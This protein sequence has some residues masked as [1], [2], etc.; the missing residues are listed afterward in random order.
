MVLRSADHSTSECPITR[1]RGDVSRQVG[2]QYSEGA[3]VAGERRYIVWHDEV[4]VDCFP[5]LGDDRGL[6]TRVEL[7]NFPETPTKTP[8]S[9][10][11]RRR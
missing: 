2:G 7:K 3:I 1:R 4:P 5:S 6:A 11:W 8:P 10:R 9:E